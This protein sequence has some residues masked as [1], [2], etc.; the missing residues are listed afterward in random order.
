[1]EITLIFVLFLSCASCIGIGL[2]RRNGMIWYPFLS[3]VV[4]MGWVF[5]QI[6][7]ISRS[8]LSPGY[9]LSKTVLMITLC[10]LAGWLGYSYRTES[11]DRRARNYPDRF[12]SRLALHVIMATSA[13]IGSYFFFKVYGMAAEAIRL[14]GGQ[15]TGAI[16]I[17][18]FF[19]TLLTYAFVLAIARL[20]I[21]R[22]MVPMLTV[23]FCL[24]FI[25]QRVLIQ[26]RREDTVALV[27]VV[28]LFMYFRHRWLV[29]RN[30]QIVIV[31]VGALFVASIGEYRA[32]MLDASSGL[33]WSGASLEDVGEINF[34]GNFNQ[35]GR[36]VASMEL[37]NAVLTIEG[38]E[39]AFSFDGGLSLWNRFIQYYVP[40]QLVGYELKDALQF[41][42]TD[43][44]NMFGFI[45]HVGTTDTG[46]ADA[47]RSFWYFGALIFFVIGRI[48][49]YWF[50]RA[51]TGDYLGMVMIMVLLP[52][53]LLAITHHT[54][55]FFLV[56]VSLFF[57]VIVPLRLAS[58]RRRCS[59]MLVRYG[60]KSNS[61]IVPDYTGSSDPK[62]GVR[63]P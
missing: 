10:F 54:H 45:W 33:A 38:A 4:I 32:T 42:F 48:L 60:E 16:T 18:V 14:Y 2:V 22:R 29:P 40:G 9:S 6:I 25:L 39:Q 13:L 12:Y 19:S 3:A 50:I 24:L 8:G 41:E 43:V 52:K 15:W 53:S 35:V 23:G 34:T 1:M 61:P 27:L 36:S 51:Q 31:A 5:P 58:G 56:F 63:I 28:L 44:R 37:F 47:F 30:I 11:V 21:E 62:S 7:A 57:F 20:T 46:F 49:R 17:Y 55:G 26:G 59:P